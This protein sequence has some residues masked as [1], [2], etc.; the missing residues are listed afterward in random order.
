MDSWVGV[1]ETGDKGQHKV[2]G[3]LGSDKGRRLIKAKDI[4]SERTMS[5]R[6]RRIT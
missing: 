4:A 3:Q 2:Q 6:S 5:L 1:Y